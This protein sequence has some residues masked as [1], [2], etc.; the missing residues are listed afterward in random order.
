MATLYITE[1][2]SQGKDGQAS[3]V[4]LPVVPPVAEQILTI[5]IASLASAA[6]NANTTIIR[7]CADSVCSIAWGTSPVALVTNARLPANTL[8]EFAVPRG[9]ALKVAV[10]TNV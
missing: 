3:I 10:I 1:F 7:V 8:M 5:G 6:F 2:F 4:P 9:S